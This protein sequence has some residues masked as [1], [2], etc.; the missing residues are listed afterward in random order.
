MTQG[1]Q[2]KKLFYKFGYGIS[3][4][5]RKR[6]QSNLDANEKQLDTLEHDHD[7]AN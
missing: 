6:L 4:L 2:S 5:I 1:L 7:R 3:Q